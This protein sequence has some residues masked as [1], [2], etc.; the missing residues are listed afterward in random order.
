MIRGLEKIDSSLYD[1]RWKNFRCFKD[2]DWIELSPIT[3]IIGANA[4]GKTSLIAPLLILK[5]TIESADSSLALKT[6]GDMFNAGSFQNLIYSHITTEPL[7]FSIRHKNITFD[8]GKRVGAIGTYAPTDIECEF[9]CGD[10]E[11]SPILSKFIA[12]D[13]YGRIMMERAHLNKGQYSVIKA[14]PLLF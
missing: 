10:T 8:K 1:I 4:S 11:I 5:Q 12:K 6:Q 7:S 2:T 3:A 14:G 13:M 9:C